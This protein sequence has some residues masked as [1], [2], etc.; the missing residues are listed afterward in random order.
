MVCIET[1]ALCLYM[2]VL[3]VYYIFAST[4]FLGTPKYSPAETNILDL[5]IP[6]SFQYSPLK[7]LLV[8]CLNSN[9]ESM[10]VSK[11][12]SLISPCRCLIKATFQRVRH[13][14]NQI[15]YRWWSNLTLDYFTVNIVTFHWSK[16]ILSELVSWGKKTR[17]NRAIMKLMNSFTSYS[18]Y[19]IRLKWDVSLALCMMNFSYMMNAK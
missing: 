7:L 12:G 2:T 15:C 5:S 18:R 17:V 14:S 11:R 9:W 10:K 19:K 4:S 6:L 3:C 16:G 1:C 8:H 13:F